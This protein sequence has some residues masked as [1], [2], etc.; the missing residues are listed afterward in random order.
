MATTARDLMTTDPIVLDGN[1]SVA[2]AAKR[3]RDEDVGD[4]LVLFENQIHGIVTDRDITVKTVAA[5]LDPDSRTIGGLVEEGELVSVAPDDDADTI[6]ER[7]RE[8]AVRRVPV[9][10][11]GVA[12]GIVSLGDLAASLDP[13]SVLG[14]ISRSPQNA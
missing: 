3:M 4:V 1:V 10:E 14:A 8:H 9:I 11:D 6:I 13:D 2:D 5:G 12:V 7:M